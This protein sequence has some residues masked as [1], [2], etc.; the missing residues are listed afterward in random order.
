[1]CASNC[2]LRQK[3]NTM[4]AECGKTKAS[5]KR[6]DQKLSLRF[7]SI[8]KQATELSV[9]DKEYVTLRIEIILFKI[10]RQLLLQRKQLQWCCEDGTNT[11][12]THID[13]MASVVLDFKKWFAENFRPSEMPK[14]SFDQYIKQRVSALNIQTN[15]KALKILDDMM[16]LLPNKLVVEFTDCQPVCAYNQFITLKEFEVVVRHAGQCGYARGGPRKKPDSVR[17]VVQLQLRPRHLLEIEVKA[18]TAGFLGLRTP[19]LT[20]NDMMDPINLLG[21]NGAM[22]CC[23]ILET[24]IV[25]RLWSKFEAEKVLQSLVA[26]K[27]AK[28]RVRSSSGKIQNLR[29][30]RL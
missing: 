29:L 25:V 12:R 11:V 27:R 17:N 30:N 23:R 26:A 9:K 2:C 6:P 19:A 20:V 1:M 14:W 10:D 13:K 18:L 5:A 8:L 22:L 7:A 24:T 3:P 16:E 4:S 21:Y 15:S 28:T